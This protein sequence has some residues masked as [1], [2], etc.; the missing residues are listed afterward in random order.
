M[1]FEHYIVCWGPKRDHEVLLH[2]LRYQVPLKKTH[3]P[4]WFHLAQTFHTL[5]SKLTSPLTLW[6]TCCVILLGTMEA[7]KQKLITAAAAQIVYGKPDLSLSLTRDRQYST[8][9]YTNAAIV[10]LPPEIKLDLFTW[11]ILKRSGLS[12]AAKQKGCS[13]LYISPLFQ[14]M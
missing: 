5:N 2:S 14:R 13:K 7:H 8:H 10:E 12:T 11:K 1:L 6:V 9:N 3:N 4:L